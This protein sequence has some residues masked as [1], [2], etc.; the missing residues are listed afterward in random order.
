[1]MCPV[2]DNP[3]YCEIRALITFFHAKN[4][5]AAEIHCELCAVYGQNIMSEGTVRQLCRMFKDGR[6]NIPSR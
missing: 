1:M 5:N 4:V 3:A 2:I 6:A